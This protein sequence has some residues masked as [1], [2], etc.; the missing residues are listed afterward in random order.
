MFI[1]SYISDVRARAVS[2]QWKPITVFYDYPFELF[3]TLE[4]RKRS[5][6]VISLRIL[7]WRHLSVMA[8]QLTGK[9]SN[10]KDIFQDAH[11]AP[12]V[13]QIH[14]WPEYFCKVISNEESVPMV[15]GLHVPSLPSID[16]TLLNDER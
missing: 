2:I 6:V 15:W 5:G 14:R 12:F 9:S 16:Y 4:S 11:Y 7:Q 13:R 8:S 10:N 3:L 1:Y